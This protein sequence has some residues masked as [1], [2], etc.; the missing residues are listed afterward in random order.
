MPKISS[1][2]QHVVGD[3]VI[4]RFFKMA[5]V[6]HLG[7][8]LGHIWTTHGG[9]RGLNTVQNLVMIDAVVSLSLSLSLSLCVCVCVTLVDTCN[10][11]WK[12][13]AYMAG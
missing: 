5:V 11:K 6:C 3:T 9:I 10:K 7:F 4:S 13:V 2:C 1:N 8:C 12:L